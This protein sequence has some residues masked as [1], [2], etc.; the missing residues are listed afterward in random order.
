MFFFQM[1]SSQQRASTMTESHPGSSPLLSNYSDGGENKINGL[2]DSAT[3]SERSGSARIPQLVEEIKDLYAIAIPTIATGLLTYFKSAISMHFMGKLGKDTLAGGSLAIG[4]ANIT[5]YSVISGLATGMEGI[6]SQACGARKWNLVGET[7]QCTISILMMTCIPISALWLNFE[8]LLLLFGQNPAISSIAATYLAYSIPDLL[9]QSLIGPLKI[10]LRTQGVTLPLMYTAALT[11]M[12]HAIMNY[13]V[14]HTIG[15][16]IQGIALV[17]AFTNLTF[18][19][20]LVLYI[21]VSGVCS[22]SWQGWSWQCFNH[23]KPILGQGVPSCVSVCLEWWWY[24]LLVLFSGLLENAAD[25]VSTYGIIIQATSFMYNFPNALGLAV[26]TKVGNELGANR[27]N[28]AK[29]SSYTALLCA[30]F[31]A[32]VAMLSM[33]SASNVWGLMFTDDEAILSLLSTTLPIVGLCELGNCPQTTICGMLCG[34]ARPG[35]GAKINFF[36]FYGAGLPV[37]L[38][39]CFRFHLGLLGLFLGLLSAQIV[40]AI[41]MVVALTRTDWKEQANRAKKLTGGIGE[42]NGESS[43]DVEGAGAASVCF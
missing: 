13:V 18:I 28:K 9:C 8:S 42:T 4:M 25:N 38:L 23:W 2:N 24:E 35:L 11:L 19:I 21:W 15:L 31:T 20:V 43:G 12:L 6:S 26:S 10:F 41:S 1:I 34:S 29:S 7:L 16:G 14:I 33:V 36:S 30:C 3:V 37:G 39:L 17:G 27:P 40:C 5:G 32:I 22:Q